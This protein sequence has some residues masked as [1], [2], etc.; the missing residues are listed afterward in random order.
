M[1][2][3]Y[4]SQQLELALQLGTSTLFEA[5]GLKNCALDSQIRPVWAGAE[6][7]GPA[8]PVACAPGDNLCIQLALEQAPEGSILVV[9]TDNFIAGY[10]GEVLSVA[11]KA[12]NIK[13]LII[14]GGVRDIS[15]LRKH[16]FPVFSRGI[17]VR[18]TFKDTFISVG[19]PIEITGTPVSSCDLVI[20]DEDGVVILPADKAETIMQKGVE[21]EEKE[22]V[23]M[24]QLMEGAT[25]VEL[26]GLQAMRE[27][28]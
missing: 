8:F 15:A 6:V 26:M 22:R 4:S 16:Q 27:K 5:S 21:R 12:R 9:T 25:T 1:T 10:W 18:G 20:A 7:S 14:D 24:N 3:A 19:E 17:S 23:M 2:S 11:A 13:G 28:I